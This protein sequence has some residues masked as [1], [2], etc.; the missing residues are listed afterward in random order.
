MGR[1]LALLVATYA[2]QDDGLRQL[3]APAHDAEALAEVLRDPEIA[4]FEVTTLVNEPHHR[5]GAALGDLLHDRRHD[6]LVLLYFTGH[7]LKDD[8]G[9]LHLA[10]TDTRRTNLMFTALSAERIHQAMDACMSRRQVLVLDCCYSGAGARLAKADGDVHTLDRFGGRGRTVLTASDAMQYSFEGD[11]VH[12]SAAQS[13]FTRHLVQ[14][15]RDGSADL[16]G[17]GDIT[18]DELYTYV[19]DRVVAEMPQQRP[20][21][22]EEVQGR[23]V[24]AHN[25]NWTLPEHLR[26]ALDSPLATDRRGAVA[27]LA[28]LYDTGNA[29]VRRR[30]EEELRRLTEDDSRS[31][32]AAAAERLA[33]RARVPAPPPM[34]EP[35]LGPEPTPLPEPVP[36]PTPVSA[37]PPA[38][39]PAPVLS[40]AAPPLAGTERW[41]FRTSGA[42]RST[43]AVANG[44]VYVADDSGSVYAVDTD[45]QQKWHVMLQVGGIQSVLEVVGD[46]V[47]LTGERHLCAI[48]AR[49]GRVRWEKKLVGRTTPNVVVADGE[50]YVGDG[51]GVA[52]H[53][54]E[55]GK[56][57]GRRST[58]GMTRYAWL[59]RAGTTIIVGNRRS[60]VFSFLTDSPRRG[61]YAKMGEPVSGP[62]ALY[63][64]RIHIGD[65]RGQLHAL[66]IAHGATAWRFDTGGP[67]DRAPTAVDGTVYVGNRDGRLFALDAA[68]G[69]QK[70]RFATGSPVRTSPTVAGRT[71]CFGCEDGNVYALDAVTG[72]E[73]WRFATGGPVRSSPVVAD[74]VVYAGSDNGRLYAVEAAD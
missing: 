57:S 34:P 66:D 67:V 27:L 62:L 54:A 12:G 11:Q 19:H 17:D 64:G 28:H 60:H 68:A 29:T 21:K 37:P 73:R 55:D 46:T 47:Y 65:A 53:D 39:A 1:R 26:H 20:K 24:I 2:Y 31:V 9:R 74:G 22:L 40:V 5:V 8:E 58:G 43:P 61:W 16:D 25:V 48:D 72:L 7:G 52:T 44:L 13:V 50:V 15:L 14:G 36:E 4:G 18:L 56:P 49:T 69:E 3:T 51:A 63:D 23:T 10:T 70:W 71:V 45:G 35:P 32:S 6:D 38:P 59:A 42:I 30:A 33:G 41:S